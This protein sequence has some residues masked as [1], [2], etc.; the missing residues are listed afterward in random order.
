[1]H[2]ERWLVIPLKVL[3]TGTGG[4]RNKEKGESGI[5]AKVTTRT[6][7]LVQGRAVHNDIR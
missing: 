4:I 2:R 1:M 5:V 6:L 3:S 7:G